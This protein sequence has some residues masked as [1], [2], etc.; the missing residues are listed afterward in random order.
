MYIQ[1]SIGY[2]WIL[3]IADVKWRCYLQL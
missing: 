1:N 3:M 2:T